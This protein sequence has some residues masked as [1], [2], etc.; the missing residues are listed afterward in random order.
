MRRIIT[1]PK[2]QK[3]KTTFSIG[4]RLFPI[5]LVAG[6]RGLLTLA[7]FW[8]ALSCGFVNFDDPDCVSANPHVQGGFTWEAVKWACLNT[9]QHAY[10][11]PILWLSHLLACQLFGLNP[12]GHHL[13][14]VLLHAANTAL[15]F[16][17]FRRLTGATRRS[18]LLAALFALHPL[19]V[20]SVVWVTERKDVLS[21]LFWLLTLWAYVKYV[22]EIHGKNSKSKAWFGLALVWFALGLMS[23]A[24]LVTLPGVLLLLDF[25]PLQR[26]SGDPRQAASKLRLILE[27]IPFFCLAAAASTVTFVVQKHGVGLAAAE[28]LPFGARGGN[29]LISYWRYLA[30]MFWPADL[31]VLYPHPGYWPLATVSLAG[32]LLAGLSILF[33]LKRRYQPYLLVGWF[34]FVGT[35]IPVIGLVQVGEQAMADRFTYL[36][37]LGVLIIVVWGAEELTRHWRHQVMILTVAGLT[38]TGLCVL[39]TRQ[40]IGYWQDSETLFRHALAVTKNNYVAHNNLGDALASK[41]LLIEAD[42]HFREAIRLKPDDADAYYNLGTILERQGNNDEAIR[43]L[44]TAIRLNP[45]HAEAYYNL[46][47]AFFA[48]NQLDEAS[49]QFQAALRLKPDYVKASYNLGI[50]FGRQGQMDLAIRQFQTTVR[51]Q[52]DYTEAHYNLGVALQANGRLSEAGSAYQEALRENPDYAEAHQN[53]GIILLNQGQI[54]EAIRQ[55]QLALHTK[56]DFIEARNNLAHAKDLKKVPSNK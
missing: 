47:N 19:R 1:N 37:S 6:L 12:W 40:Q 5:G 33:F 30:E 43:P 44:Q 16:L 3:A 50:A 7:V 14:N 9:E 20:E 15:V 41:G 31:A 34:W 49:Q 29:A 10:W 11:A 48:Q 17:V 32:G 53:W 8:P 36:P 21:G 51:L 42:E 28:S 24:M 4:R 38:T 39:A 35:L 18:L 23:K 54:D 55:F 46:G 27:K 2:S 52:P 56:P 25:W 13:L 26:M 22:E 45:N